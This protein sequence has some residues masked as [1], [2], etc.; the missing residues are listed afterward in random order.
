MV[1]SWCKRTFPRERTIIEVLAPWRIPENELCPQ[2]AQQFS[3]IDWRTCC[4]S[5]GKKETEFCSD[6]L[7]WEETCP[8]IQLQH[9]AL[10]AYDQ[11]MKDWLHEYKLMGNYQLRGTFAPVIKQKLNRFD[12]EC[13]IPIP[14]SAERYQQ[15]GFNQFTAVLEAAGVRFQELLEKVVD[16]AP[17]AQR[18]R[19]QRLVEAQPFAVKPDVACEIKGKKLLLIDDV[20]TTGRTLYHA[21]EALQSFGPQS[22]RSF[23]IAR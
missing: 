13:L 1:C 19:R 18:S 22:I 23:S 20:Y 4:P 9:R 21:A 10:F 5:C 15:R 14:L 8:M 17:Q 7:Y 11:G 6:C 12:Y 16:T 2:C 3:V